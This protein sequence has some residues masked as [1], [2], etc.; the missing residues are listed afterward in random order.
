[1][2]PYAFRTALA[3]TVGL[4]VAALSALERATFILSDGA[5]MSGEIVFH[6]EART[7][8]RE[9]K[10]EF[11]LKVASGQEVPIPFDHVVY[12][13]F[14]GGT[15]QPAEFKGLPAPGSHFLVLRNG[16]T[17]GGRLL[18]FIG[19]T[20]VKWDTGTGVTTMAI[21]DVRRIYLKV[22]R[23]RELFAAAVAEANATAAPATPAAPAATPA[24]PRTT[25]RSRTIEVRGA[26]AWTDTG[27]T[28]RAGQMF[29]FYA[30]GEMRYSNDPGATA[31][32]G[33]KIGKDPSFPVPSLEVGGLIAKIGGNGRP[34]A[35]GSNQ[36]PIRMPGSGRLMLGVNDTVFTDNS[37]VFE[38][39]V[40]PQ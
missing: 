32:P 38:V 26:D 14:A 1:M 31:G 36:D 9:D 5:R 8:I 6:T 3:L 13:D 10:N 27:I 22:D 7:N 39:I 29:T 19:G 11:N 15:P 4:S 16:D 2:K 33:G 23:V 18:D 17:R 28:V 37:G 20:T 12:I 25:S 30:T 35:I 21:A 34:F 24:R 40:T